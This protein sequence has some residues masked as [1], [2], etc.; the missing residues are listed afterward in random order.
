MHNII[1]QTP[2]IHLD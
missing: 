1:L 2:F